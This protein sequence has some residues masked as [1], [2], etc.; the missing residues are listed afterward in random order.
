MLKIL[1]PAAILEANNKYEWNTEFDFDIIDEAKELDRWQAIA[2]E[3]E[4]YR[5]E[6]VVE[7]LEREYPAI[8]TWRCWPELKK[9]G[10]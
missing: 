2:R 5:T 8:T 1:S 3:A 4:R 7:L 10:G 9:Q 6:Q